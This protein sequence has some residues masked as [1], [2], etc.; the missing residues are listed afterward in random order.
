[1]SGAASVNGDKYK[2]LQQHVNNL[3]VR[4][5]RNLFSYFRRIDMDNPN[6]LFPAYGV[7]SGEFAVMYIQNMTSKG[8]SKKGKKRRAASEDDDDGGEEEDDAVDAL[9]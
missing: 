3:K 7:T 8:G 6:I 5:M 9:D 2:T 1:M 4:D